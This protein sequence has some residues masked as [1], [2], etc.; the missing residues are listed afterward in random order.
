VF[1]TSL[2]LS[3]CLGTAPANLSPDPSLDAEWEEWKINFEKTYSPDEERYRRT[4]WEEEEKKKIEEHN[5]EYQQDKM[6]FYVGLN[7]FSDMTYEEF[8]KI[9]C[10]NLVW[11]GGLD[12]DIHEYKDLTKDN[13]IIPEKDQ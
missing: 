13:N 11:T 6:S 5:T 12:Y 3:Y 1:V 9:C 10:G 2:V 8:R 7:E 4:V